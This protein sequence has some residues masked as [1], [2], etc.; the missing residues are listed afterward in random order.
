MFSSCCLQVW[1]NYEEPKAVEEVEEPVERN[2]SYK[3]VVVT[4]VEDSLKFYAQNVDNGEK[5]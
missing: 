2:I 3:T 4:E 5:T 1:S